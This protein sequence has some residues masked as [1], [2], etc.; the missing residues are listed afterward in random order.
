MSGSA[1]LIRGEKTQTAT[2]QKMVLTG[3]LWLEIGI[4]LVCITHMDFEIIY[5]SE[6][7][8]TQHTRHTEA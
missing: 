4:T 7:P 5:S 6:L 3:N 1:T 2:K 8:S